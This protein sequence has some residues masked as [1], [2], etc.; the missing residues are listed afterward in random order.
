MPRQCRVYRI[1]TISTYLT[2]Q[3]SAL[4]DHVVRSIIII[5]LTSHN[6]QILP[7]EF[8]LMV[9]KK[10]VSVH[11][12]TVHIYLLLSITLYTLNNMFIT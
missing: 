4:H 2:P 8:K 7:M 6:Y 10:E 3:Q 9:R 1:V 12:L 11:T 5:L